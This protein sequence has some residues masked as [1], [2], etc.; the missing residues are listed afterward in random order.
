M[1]P[2]APCSPS[3]RFASSCYRICRNAFLWLLLATIGVRAYSQTPDSLNPF[4]NSFVYALSLQPDGKIVVGGEFTRLSGQ[5][6]NGIGR[7]NADGSLDAAF[8]P[9]GGAV[10]A[11]AIQSDGRIIVGGI[12][13]SLGGQ[14]RR[15]I[16]RLNANGTIDEAF[17]LPASNY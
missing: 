8:N 10:N 11:L 2:K 17:N 7:L 1:H 15:N 14:A 3:Q 13:S 6:R 16:G 9:G 12:F 4:P 5:S